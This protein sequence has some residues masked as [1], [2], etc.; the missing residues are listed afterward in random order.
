MQQFTL[1]FQPGISERYPRWKD[2]FVHVVYG[3]RFG[4]NGIAAKLDMSPSELSKRLSETEENR[5]LRIEDIEGIL[6]ATGD[7]TPIYW[8]LDRFLKDPDAKRQEALARLPG[9]LQAIEALLQ[10]AGGNVLK[11][12]R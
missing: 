7:Y 2:T 8:L 6:E 1:D 4:L 12:V 11:A 10:Q 3:S 5:P 9:A